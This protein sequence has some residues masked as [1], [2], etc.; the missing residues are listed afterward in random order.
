MLFILLVIVCYLVDD[1]LIFSLEEDHI[2]ENSVPI[3][4]QGGLLNAQMPKHR[5]K[6]PQ[7]LRVTTKNRHVTICILFYIFV[8]SVNEPGICFLDSYQRE[9]WS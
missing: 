3:I 5:Q 9:T 6:S 4:S 8:A 7:R 2:P 1:E